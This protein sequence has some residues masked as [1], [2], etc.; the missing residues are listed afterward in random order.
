MEKET[1]VTEES[2]DW[3]LRGIL[4]AVA[5]LCTAIIFGVKGNGSSQNFP[6]RVKW[7]AILILRNLR[8]PFSK[9]DEKIRDSKRILELVYNLMISIYSEVYEGGSE[10]RRRESDK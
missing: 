10:P 9:T 6:G 1:K 2:S 8:R 4:T 5:V 7:L 3:L